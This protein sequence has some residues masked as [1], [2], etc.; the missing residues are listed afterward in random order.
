MDVSRCTTHQT[1][2]D[3]ATFAI[4]SAMR[5]YSHPAVGLSG[6]N[7]PWP[8]YQRMKHDP[9]TQHATFYV[10][11]ERAVAE[12][13]PASNIGTI[14]KIFPNV[15]GLKVD[16]PREEAI[17]DYAMELAQIPDHSLDLMILGMGK[18]GHIA[19]LF[20]HSDGLEEQEHLVRHTMTTNFA[21]PDRYT[22]TPAMIKA[23]KQVILLLAGKKKKLALQTLLEKKKAVWD[24]PAMMLHEHPNCKLFY[25]EESQYAEPAS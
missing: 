22:M 24:F 4:L 15:Q 7:T 11:D 9:I 5:E 1:F 6:G 3:K 23:A 25:S 8:I 13:H 19:S 21:I 16:K 2:V 20:P 12:H 18:D 17:R 10:V 14:R